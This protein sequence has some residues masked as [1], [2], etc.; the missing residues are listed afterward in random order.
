MNEHFNSIWRNQTIVQSVAT[1]SI[2][3]VN[4]CLSE[5]NEVDAQ[6]ALQNSALDSFLMFLQKHFLIFLVWR[7]HVTYATLSRDF[8]WAEPE[9]GY[10]P[11]FSA[12]WVISYVVLYTNIL[13]KQWG[14]LRKCQ[15]CPNIITLAGTNN[16]SLIYLNSRCCVKICWI[17]KIGTAL[18]VGDIILKVQRSRVLLGLKVK[19]FLI[20]KLC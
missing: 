10:W 11:P 15:I 4:T 16:L 9:V 12:I 2:Q 20:A 18:V 6:F 13:I 14:W 19:S 17:K 3:V 1:R 8:K 7:R 5:D